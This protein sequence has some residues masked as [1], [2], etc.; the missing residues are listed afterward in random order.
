MKGEGP[1]EEE[2]IEFMNTYLLLGARKKIAKCFFFSWAPVV[3]P[4]NLVC[5]ETVHLVYIYA[6]HQ[7]VLFCHL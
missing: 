5:E 6:H 1:G 3:Q 7:Y 2:V 4:S